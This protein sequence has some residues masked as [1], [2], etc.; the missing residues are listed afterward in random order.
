[1]ATRTR[2]Y[3]LIV[4]DDDAEGIENETFGGFNTIHV[5]DTF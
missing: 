3:R 1:M 4:F 2:Q 5:R